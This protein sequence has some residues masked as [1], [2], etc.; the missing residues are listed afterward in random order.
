MHSDFVKIVF[1]LPVDESFT[2]SVPREMAQDIA[3]GVRVFASFGKKNLTGIVISYYR[4][5][6]EYKIKPI[7]RVLDSV[8]VINEEMIK[9]CEWIS[10]YYFCPIGEVIFSAIPKSILIE[11]KIFYSVNKELKFQTG[12]KTRASLINEQVMD[13][14]FTDSK[15]VQVNK[16]QEKIIK[17]LKNKPLTLK[18]IEKNL[19]EG[20]LRHHISKLSDM[21]V[22]EAERVTTS[23]KV[24]PKTEKY[25]EFGLLDEFD[26][27]SRAMIENFARESKIKSAKQIDVLEYLIK[28]RL[29]SV[30]LKE[31]SAAADCGAGTINALVKKE[32]L[33]I[34]YREVSRIQDM[35]FAD[36]EKIAG[37]NNDQKDVLKII[38]S[39]IVRNEF[40]PFLLF[41][42]TGSGKTQIY[43]EA[44]KQIIKSSK[45]AIVLVPEIALTPQL[46]HRFSTNFGNIIGVIHSRISEGERFD[47]FRKIISGE[48]KIVIGA[49][50]ALFAPIKDLGIIIVDEEHDHSYKQTE[51]DPKYNA[52]DAAI[53][54][55]KLNNAVVVL[56]SATPS[57]ESY[58]N[59]V[60]HK[61]EMLR[62]PHR[63]LKTKQPEVEIIN[64]REEMK[65]ASKYVKFE[66]PDSKFLSSALLSQIGLALNRKQSIII[67]Q[68]R[69]GYSAY[70]ECLDCG[71][72]K[73][74]SNCDITLIYHKYGEHLRC[75]YCGYTEKLP[76]SC[77]KCGSSRIFLRGTGTEKVEEEISRIF[78]KARI[79]RMDAD[80]VTGKDAYRKILMSFHDRE[81]DILIG[82]QMISKGLDFPNVYLVGV[83]SADVGLFNPDFR[84]TERIFQLLMQVSGRS[85]R[86][87]D[88]GKVIIQTMNPENTIFPL[89]Q[90]HDYVSF[91]IREIASRALFNYPP[92]S[93]MTLVEV[94][95]K[96]AGT[97]NS[98]SSKIYLF[99]KNNYRSEN[100]EIMKPAPAIIYKLKNMYRY[101]LI[102]KSL[103]YGI[104]KEND[105]T[106]S[107]DKIIQQLKSY[108]ASDNKS[109]L[110]NLTIEA[111]P[112]SFY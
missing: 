93:R 34:E 108:I 20:N 70:L 96:N 43:I 30:K 25:I 74:C 111:D 57:V 83:I 18:Q 92:F 106:P 62:L 67:L 53:V 69:R 84:S 13:S 9:F 23:E 46:I 22:I 7:I 72:V 29:S 68:N 64:M 12:H 6:D 63:A 38:D 35:E 56:G 66:T 79:K 36:E 100:I 91:Y 1:N 86:S 60:N 89:I 55:A 41:G 82:T 80:T 104:K 54:R 97:A 24:K 42:V 33:K 40:M 61:Y 15:P 11:S 94:K 59:A 65:S 107:T 58:F 103:K 99:L 21:K 26:G 31:L 27:F 39:S 48:I 87:S 17:L 32:L 5:D 28:H 81:F 77:D 112:L 102:I 75:H 19:G 78:P 52:R 51:K 110:Q 49:R 3:I 44:I 14:L 10:E 98:I 16:I 76:K 50:S 2:Y 45:T 4:P 88:F 85:G 105:I 37:L 73:K 71:N 8:P 47:V 109:H 101:H 95:H 90:K